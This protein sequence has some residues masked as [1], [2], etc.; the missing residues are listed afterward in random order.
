MAKTGTTS[1]PTLITGEPMTPTS[2]SLLP[3]KRSHSSG[4]SS[5]ARVGSAGKTSKT[6]THTYT[7]S[8]ERRPQINGHPSPL[9]LPVS[10]NNNHADTLLEGYLKTDDR[11]RLAKERRE[12]REK[13]LAARDQLVK[14]KERRARLQYERTVEERWRRLEEQRQK[15]E[16]R[17]AAVEEKRRQQLE[18]EKERLEALMRRSLERSLQLEQRNRRWNRGY[19][20]GAG[21]S[22]TP[23][24]LSAASAL[25]HGIASPLPASS[26][27]APCSPHRSPYRGTLNPA[28]HNRASLQ[29]GSQST[30]NT[31][32]K[33][34]LRRDRRTASP[35]Y[36][37]PVRKPESPAHSGRQLTC[38][39]SSKLTPKMRTGSP[40]SARQ[41]TPSPIRHQSNLV[42]DGDRSKSKRSGGHCEESKM[43]ASAKRNT[44][45]ESLEPSPVQVEGNKEKPLVD[46]GTSKGAA[47]E[48]SD[49][50]ES[51]LTADFN[52]VTPMGGV[53]PAGK[54]SAGTT[55]AEEASKLLAERRRQAREHKELE[56]KRQQQEREERLKAEKLRKELQ[57]RLRQEKKEREKQDEL[58]RQREEEEK[59]LL[60]EEQDKE[61]QSQMEKE[62]EKCKE[63]D[64][65]ETERQR[66]E[67]ELQKIQ[68]EEERHLRKKRI[69]EIMK[70]TRKGEADLK[71]SLSGEVST[72]LCA[73]SSAG[74]LRTN[75][76]SSDMANEQAI[77]KVTLQVRAQLAAQAN[78]KN[79]ASPKKEVKEETTTQNLEQTSVQV[80]A[81]GFHRQES[82]TKNLPEPAPN[83]KAASA[84]QDAQ[85]TKTVV[86]KEQERQE[87]DR[88][89]E[90]KEQGSHQTNKEP[91]KQAE[92]KAHQRESVVTNGNHAKHPADAP[93]NQN[94]PNAAEVGKQNGVG[95]QGSGAG[96]STPERRGHG[97]SGEKKKDTMTASLTL[98]SVGRPAPPTITL[99]PLD[100]RGPGSGDE[101]QSM[102]V[103]P[104]SKEELISI[105]EFSPVNEIHSVSN[106]CALDDLLDLTG[107]AAGQHARLASD[108]HAGG[109]LN[110]NLIQGVVSPLAE[111]KAIHTSSSSVVSS[112]KLSIK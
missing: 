104:V 51:H 95:V 84:A 4:N 87:V 37:S 106:S 24:P 48:T 98:P 36:G 49:K 109:D 12:E 111:S 6:H 94:Q 93:K 112:K 76:H 73:L 1:S 16:L 61:L 105:P 99:E 54:A 55:S 21:D 66:Q 102:E 79:Q 65:E 110:K 63:Q 107:T 46:A 50:G 11:M 17:R 30:P 43:D 96:A 20:A 5:P 80:K 33:H 86:V 42:S 89:P 90:E 19:P 15:E 47:N 41:Q 91:S 92:A 60:K 71:C 83:P 67:R 52:P 32:K 68:E 100:V 26:E 9:H 62:K 53:A 74:E 2:P 10:H 59:K 70:R 88:K 44:S 85:V 40:C 14:E 56:D 78:M 7:P 82:S 27:S 77:Q 72:M 3:D 35:A 45:A 28:D 31:P 18:E 69:E 39:S 108:G 29:G 81:N 75:V 101:V 57:E 97:G 13:S 34:R 23:P 64:G 8:T 58:L 103:S 25:P 38:P 22:E